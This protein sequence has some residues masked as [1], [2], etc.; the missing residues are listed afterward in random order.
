MEEYAL[1][2]ATRRIEHGLAPHFPTLA[3]I[4]TRAALRAS[5]F[6]RAHGDELEA[7]VAGV[8]WDNSLSA[9]NIE[10]GKEIEGIPSLQRLGPRHAALRC[11]GAGRRGQDAAVC[12]R[13]CL[14]LAAP[15]AGAVGGGVPIRLDWL[16][17]RLFE[18]V[19]PETVPRPRR[20]GQSVSDHG[21]VAVE[22]RFPE[23]D[24]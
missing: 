24:R 7:A 3:A 8:E 21:A 2:E 11:R 20:G 5:D 6:Y 18:P 19:A 16:S 9:W 1:G 14:A 15:T 13:L 22:L 23:E 17:G 10:R 12:A 4:P